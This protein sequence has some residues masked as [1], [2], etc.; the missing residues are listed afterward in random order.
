MI[1]VN[2]GCWICHSYVV[3]TSSNQSHCIPYRLSAAIKFEAGILLLAAVFSIEVFIRCTYEYYEYY[4]HHEHGTPK[5][6]ETAMMEWHGLQG[7][8]EVRNH[9]F[10]VNLYQKSSTA[11]TQNDAVK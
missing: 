4:I 8:T 11:N 10:V 3:C 2:Q 1:K 9:T 6:N 7:P 5:L